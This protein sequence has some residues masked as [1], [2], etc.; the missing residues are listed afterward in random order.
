MKTIV[1][2]IAISVFLFMN[3]HAESFTW[4]AHE[5][6][7]E[8]GMTSDSLS[9]QISPVFFT[10]NDTRRDTAYPSNV[11]AVGVPEPAT[12][13]LLGTGLIGLASSVRRNHKKR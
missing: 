3:A 13:F 12:L 4:T 10:L 6:L 5:T 1:M 2:M 8:I 7:S 11:K 9:A